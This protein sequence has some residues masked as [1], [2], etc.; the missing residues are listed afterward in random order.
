MKLLIREY[1]ADPFVKD[2][3]HD[4]V[5]HMAIKNQSTDISK[6][7]VM[8]VDFDLNEINE[9]TTLTYFSYAVLKN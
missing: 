7:L 9:R 1:D 4:N 3:N 5:L 6:F 2:S 8:H